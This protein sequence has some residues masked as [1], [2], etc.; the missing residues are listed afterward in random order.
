MYCAIQGFDEFRLSS[1]PRQ[2]DGKILVHLGQSPGWQKLHGRHPP[3]SLDSDENFKPEHTLFW[4]ELRFVAIYALYAQ[5]RRIWRENCKLA[6][7]ENF[8]CHYCSRWETAKFCHPVRERWGQKGRGWEERKWHKLFAYFHH[9]TTSDP[10][11][12]W[13]FAFPAEIYGEGGA[14][15]EKGGANRTLCN[16]FGL[17]CKTPALI[18]S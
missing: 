11:P 9:T 6:L 1:E 13:L 2:Q 12:H 10:L 14:K 5:K 8:H 7:D 3:K 17:T 4:R 18:F 16:K 15:R